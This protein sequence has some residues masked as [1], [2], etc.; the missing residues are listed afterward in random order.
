MAVQ[1][2]KGQ[3]GK[4]I[5]VQHVSDK[6]EKETKPETVSN[7]SGLSSGRDYETI[8]Q[9]NKRREAERQKLIEEMLKNE[10]SL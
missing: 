3:I 2:E 9:M 5:Q 8:G 7:K 1:F 6:P 4:P 10:G